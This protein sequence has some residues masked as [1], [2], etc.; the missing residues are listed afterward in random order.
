MSLINDALRRAKEAQQP[1]AP[2]PTSNLQF[3]PV[4]PAQAPSRRGLGLMLPV[5]AGVMALLA[6]LLVWQLAGRHEVAGPVVASAKTPPAA[7][8]IAAEP[9]ASAQEA[10]VASAP[11]PVTASKADSQPASQ[12]S[13]ANRAAEAPANDAAASETD[14]SAA[15]ADGGDTTNAPAVTAPPAP[16]PA[17]L[18]LQAIV[19]DPARPS[20]MVSGKTLFVGDRLGEFR[21]KAIDQES[22]TLVSAGQTNILTLSE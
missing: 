17:P 10:V 4:D 3:R 1:A 5:V 7:P 18:R 20:A 22:L 15:E 19:F 21:V 16:K 2:P 11:A 12:L 8:A 6:L 14:A 9:A 13:P